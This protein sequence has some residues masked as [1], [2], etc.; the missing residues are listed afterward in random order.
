VPQSILCIGDKET[1]GEIF[2]TMIFENVTLNDL[3][4]S[5]AYLYAKM[6]WRGTWE[7][8]ETLSAG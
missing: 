4:K 2:F 1:L 8:Y 5:C 3:G 7:K 6:F